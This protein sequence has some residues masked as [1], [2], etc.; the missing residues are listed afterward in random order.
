M[1]SFYTFVLS[2]ILLSAGTV[3]S[4]VPGKVEQLS[5]AQIQEFIQKAQASGLS[6]AQI[7]QLAL[8]R[9]YTQQ[10]VIKMRDRI[11]K[12]KAGQTKTASS[13][14]SETET[15]RKQTE[16]VAEKAPTVVSKQQST[17]KTEAEDNLTPTQT[18]EVFGSSFFQNATLSFEPNLRIATPKNYSLGPEDELNVEI[19]GSSVQSYKLKVSPEGSIRIEN[20]GPILVNGLTIEEAKAKIATRLRQLYSMPGIGINVTL[21]NV[22]SIKVTITGEVVRPGSYTIS[23]LAT[24]FNAIYQSG[25]PTPNGSFRLI[26]LRRNNK[27]VRTIDLYDFLLK[28]DE[29]DNV[30]L[31]DQ[32]VLVFPDYQARVELSGE[33]RRPLIFEIKEGET[34]KDVFQFAG[35]F[36]DQAYTATI[37]VRRN[38]SKELK[39]LNIQQD[40]FG[41]FI[42]QNGDR[43]TVGTILDRYENRVQ[44]AGAVFRPGEYALDESISTLK[45]LVQKAEGVRGDAFLDRIFIRREKDNLDVENISVDL[46][47]LLKGEVEDIKLQRQDFV[48]IKSIDELREKYMVSIG[49]A[50]NNG[51]NFEYT[52][53]MTLSD[54]VTL[55]G[56]FAEGAVSSRIEVS[57]RIKQEDTTAKLKANIQVFTL[58]IDKDL[59]ITSQEKVFTLQPYDVIYVRTDPAYEAQ[60]LV[61]IVGEVNYPGNYAIQRKDERLVDLIKRAGGL[62]DKAFLKAARFYRQGELVAVD[63]EKILKNPQ[64][65]DNLRLEDKDRLLIPQKDELV[66]IAG[67][68]LNP[69]TVN[70]QDNSLE[71]YIAQAGGYTDEAIRKKVYVTYANGRI[72][73]TKRV[74]GFKHYPKIEPGATIN[75][76]IEDKANYRKMEPS[77]RIALF[78]LV[79]SLLIATGTIISALLR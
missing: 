67:G 63:L 58:S 75:V 38:T 7:E 29:K 16:E 2:I 56:G 61:E 40:F 12:L 45:Q 41:S 65:N 22:R 47:K 20:S 72:N 51:G 60:K 78:S 3:Y 77:E 36:T 55:A 64:S 30:G 17:S 14:S 49:G 34:L 31:R 73:T 24:V 18:K 42:P 37:T 46:G 33:V 5:D 50:V 4:Q 57:R 70:Y 27:L 26:Q 32:D 19:F 71:K 10:D 9:G 11:A 52:E 21:G 69:A 74:L 79:G 62:K 28:G 15:A 44:I 8:Q 76:P 66:R 13:Q 35:G 1:R 59:K 68:V 53:N 54:L 43:F 48:T 6:E 25:G 39:I 23:S